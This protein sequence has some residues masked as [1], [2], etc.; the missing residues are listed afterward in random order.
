MKN[1]HRMTGNKS[2]FTEKADNDRD[3][4]GQF[5]FFI[6]PTWHVQKYDAEKS[7]YTEHV[8]KCS[9]TKAVDI[10][11]LSD[12]NLFLIEVKDFRN[13]RIEN[14]KRMNNGDLVKEFA[15][16]IRDTIEIISRIIG[17][18]DKTLA[19]NLK[20]RRRNTFHMKDAF[21]AIKKAT[22][23]GIGILNG[24]IGDYLHEQQNEL[25]A[26]MNFYLRNKP[27]HLSTEKLKE[28][29]PDITPRIC[30]LVHGLTNDEN[31]WRFHDDPKMTYGSL[32][33]KDMEYT[34]FYLRYNTGRHISENGRNFSKMITALIEAY[35]VKV[36]E[37]I[38]ITHSMGGLV[39]RSACH[40]GKEEGWIEK[41]RKVYYLGTP[42]MGAPLEK[43]GNIVT[44]I[45]EAV[46]RPYIKLAS[47]II[48]LRSSG[49]KDLRFGYLVDE[50]WE[51]RDPDAPLKNNK[52]FVPLLESASHYIITGTL[53]ENP[54][55]P[56]SRMI[57]DVLVRKS[58]AL[59]RSKE[60]N[61]SIPF[62]K[63]NHR[64]FNK[65]G[66]MM[67]THNLEVYLQIKK[68]CME[69]ILQ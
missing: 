5:D 2:C 1:W 35:P 3:Y 18:R 59:G 47:D 58:S 45:L 19:E 26:V 57:G 38:L 51:G 55:H 17:V 8:K 30:I 28:A 11:A 42:H 65:M 68:W 66:H 52:H 14:K 32:L 34:P 24:V 64:E 9:G 4:R 7:Y 37:I 46:P 41:V 53:T 63:A 36:K 22:D 27:L 62:D 13:Y 39:T 10:L 6:S 67:L 29:Y 33:Q 16:K 44:N 40:Y 48:N 25:A 61:Q 49:I 43:F 21:L 31:I 69:D 60:E 20:N 23:L 50:D 12:E 15:Q 54:N 56:V